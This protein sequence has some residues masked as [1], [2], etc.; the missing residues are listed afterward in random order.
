[1][2]SVTVGGWPSDRNLVRERMCVMEVEMLAM[3]FIHFLKL[4]NCYKSI[5]PVAHK[6]FFERKFRKL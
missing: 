3:S 2:P 1:M 6:R 4:Q 5:F